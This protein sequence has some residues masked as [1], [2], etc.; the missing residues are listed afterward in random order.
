MIEIYKDIKGY[1]GYQVSNLGNVK[2][3]KGLTPRILKP[4]LAGEYYFVVLYGEN[5]RTAIV[6]KLVYEHFGTKS[7]DKLVIDHIDN[8]PL[9]NRIDN[10]Q[11]IT[12]RKNL[13][14]DK[15]N[16]TSK[17]TG[18]SWV[19]KREHW[20]STI[21]INKKQIYLGSSKSETDMRDLYN[22]KLS[23]IYE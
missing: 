3:L 6:H 1:Q 15:K 11:L 16:K 4:G 14:K 22:K 5:K 13:S 12:F 19:K 21:M 2:S 9:N 7:C 18:V 23:E 10:L 20:I 17:F 8:N